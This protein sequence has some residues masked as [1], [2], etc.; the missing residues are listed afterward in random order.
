[1]PEQPVDEKSRYV[2]PTNHLAMKHTSSLYARYWQHILT[3]SNQR[4]LLSGGRWSISITLF[5]RRISQLIRGIR[6]LL[7][8]KYVA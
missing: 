6:S 7:Q 4:T 1:M 8:D 3:S 2:L 5:Q